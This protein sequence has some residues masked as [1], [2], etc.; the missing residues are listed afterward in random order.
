MFSAYSK[1]RNVSTFSISDIDLSIVNS[2]RRTILADID[3]VAFHFDIGN[4]DPEKADIFVKVNDTPLHNEF[5]AQRIS[6][7][8]IH[9]SNDEIKHWDPEDYEFS[10]DVTNTTNAH[11]LVT[12]KDILV[13][14]NDTV[15]NK[16]REQMFPKN[17]ITNDYI[18]IT[19]LPPS[20]NNKHTKLEATLVAIKGT[21]EKSACWSAISLCTY[22][23]SID[24][25]RNKVKMD[26]Y[27]K[28]HKDTLSKDNAI[29][30]YN[31]LD[32]QRAYKRNEYCEPNHFTFKLEPECLLS[33]FTIVNNA[34]TIMCNKMQKLIEFDEDKI[35]IEK[36]DNVYSITVNEENH[37]MGNLIQ[38]LLYN[39]H[40]R[41]KKGKE[42]AFVGY[43]VPHPLDKRIVIK[44][45]L[46]P[47]FIEN[48]DYQ[49]R[50]TLIES[51]REIKLMLDDVLKHWQGFT[52]TNEQ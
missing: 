13:K 1:E 22:F 30:R 23:N 32:Y 37:T 36:S 28:K 5:L 29:V 12:S 51:F 27:V 50:D 21:A 26:E 19:K 46:N 41:M 38:A 17:A 45:T 33:P 3:N 35:T 52:A 40:V 4:R 34:L 10:I 7:I 48:A 16:L 25:K 15:D 9:L 6:M 31:T 47:D 11:V 20:T 44:I 49:M 43:F 18:S 8:P 42:I 39:I 24:E 14:K 2:L